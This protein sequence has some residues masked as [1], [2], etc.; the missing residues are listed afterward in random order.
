MLNDLDMYKMS[1]SDESV[2]R[3]TCL[4]WSGGAGTGHAIGE[5]YRT[6]FLTGVPN[7]LRLLFTHESTPMKRDHQGDPLLFE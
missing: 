4:L 3:S 5:L 2:A 7:N 1:V 6:A